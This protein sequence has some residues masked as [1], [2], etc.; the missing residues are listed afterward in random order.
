MKR[1]R[2]LPPTYLVVSIVVMALLHFLVPI[3]E[4]IVYPW[5]LFGIIPL[6]AGITLNLIADSAFKKAQTT[7]K[8]FEIST[9][10]ITTGMFQICRHPMY[11]GMVLILSGL[12]IF[13][14][15]FTPFII[16]I[17]FAFLMELVFVRKEE[18]MLKQQFGP[19][20]DAYKNKV[21][22]WV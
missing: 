16:V 6:A 11:L 13:M 17:I 2:V 4:L 15:S 7:V 21:R 5:T 20:W 9:V 12:A 22:K 14:G 10:L 8:P 3:S 1:K 19:T 18:R